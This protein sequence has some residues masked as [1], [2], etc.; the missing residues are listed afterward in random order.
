MRYFIIDHYDIGTDRSVLSVTSDTTTD[1]VLGRYRIE[2]LGFLPLS[3]DVDGRR[4]DINDKT[5]RSYLV[6]I[7]QSVDLKPRLRSGVVCELVAVN[8]Y[9]NPDTVREE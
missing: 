5:G 8:C 3:V 4:P 1:F 9:D 6:T 2:S 7:T